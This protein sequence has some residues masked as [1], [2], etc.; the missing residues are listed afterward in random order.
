M[1]SRGR[2]LAP[3]A[4]AAVVAVVAG[5]V[6]A[7]PGGVAPAGASVGAA[8]PVRN[9]V[10]VVAAFYPLAEAA[11]RVGGRYVRVE[12]LTPAGAE[13]HDLE[14]TTDDRD[15]IEDAGL[16]IVMGKDFQPAIEDAAGERDRGTLEVLPALLA[17]EAEGKKVAPE[18]ESVANALDPHVWLD[19]VLMQHVVQLV[20]NALAKVD[21]RHA[22]IYRANAAAYRA[23]IATLDADYRAGLATC[24]RDLVVTSHEAFGYLA[25]RYGLRQRGVVG[26]APDAEPNPKRL[27]ALI[28]LV[29]KNGVT[30]IFT[31]TLVSPRIAE[32]LAREAGGLKTAVL[33]PLEGLSA[34]QA[35]RGEDYLSLMHTNLTKLR[36]ALGCS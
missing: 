11:S 2:G 7:T 27:D 19:P 14:L 8:D 17:A 20:A 29:E 10:R 32:T 33:N 28:A 3:V 15:A 12:N 4:V 13:P 31:E 23:R 36:A 26:I 35:R 21:R 5:M 25:K 34:A 18:G 16:V 22:A 6:G 24:A 1:R 9:P 30:T